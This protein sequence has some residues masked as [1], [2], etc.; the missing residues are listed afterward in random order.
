MTVRVR[1]RTTIAFVRRHRSLAAI[2]GVIS[3]GVIL[4]LLYLR[5]E[6][7]FPLNSD[8][9]AVLLEAR[10]FVAGNYLLS[11]WAT[12]SF[13]GY[14][15]KLPYF[16]VGIWLFGFRPGLLHVIP[17]IIFT[18][19]VL[20]SL[21]LVY[22]KS[23]PGESII[24]IGIAFAILGLPLWNPAWLLMPAAQH[25][26]TFLLAVAAI[27]CVA[28]IEKHPQEQWR[29]Y[30]LFTIL[31]SAA[32]FDDNFA[33]YAALIPVLIVLVV[34]TILAYPR[35]RF[36]EAALAVLTAL[37]ALIGYAG[38]R[39]VAHEGGFR[40]FAPHAGFAQGAAA[41]LNNLSLTIRGLL[42]L[43]GVDG[44]L[45]GRWWLTGEKWWLNDP[46]AIVHLFGL[47]VVAIA[48]WRIAA[49]FFKRQD[50]GDL[51]VQI[52]ALG[53]AVDIGAYL[54]SDVSRDIGTTRYLAPT[55]IYGGIIGGIEASSLL[56]TRSAKLLAAGV[57]AVYVASSV[58][59]IF[60]RPLV[61]LNR[62]DVAAAH[63][64]REHRLAN[65]VGEYW[66][67]AI[68]TVESRGSVK[69]RPV[70]VVPQGIAP[71]SLVGKP[72][73]YRV[74]DGAGFNF[75]VIDKTRQDTGDVSVANIERLFGPAAQRVDI[76]HY[77]ILVWNREL[78]LLPYVPPF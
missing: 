32:V 45:D 76:G 47:A 9:A 35:I 55:L 58:S 72:Q 40:E 38:S 16:E 28:H 21:W 6:K 66:G 78:P 34:R 12:G 64:L 70:M 75:V 46:A 49:R 63:W 2:A 67:S 20:L 5:V 51:I 59:S 17:P 44:A 41:L 37:S 8:D 11:G 22:E 73:W 48:I 29:L 27:L 3:A 57:A 24:A 43:F 60:L 33:F 31:L 30:A 19:L 10:D 39:I 62:D 77:T 61:N 23:R 36:R 26:G 68:L 50:H 71:Y 69:V 42:V 14:F 15:S 25:A 53:I 65:G 74:M 4:F 7:T 1:L 18:I 13:C 54:I 56:A 52:L